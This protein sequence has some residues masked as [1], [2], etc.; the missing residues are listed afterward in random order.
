LQ[1]LTD[2]ARTKLIDHLA[3]RRKPRVDATSVHA[4]LALQ[5]GVA[6]ARSLHLC[7]PLSG[8][9]SALG[10]KEMLVVAILTFFCVV[11]VLAVTI[12]LVGEI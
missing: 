1:P 4:R 11:V 3:R 12:G 2:G 10:Q 9:S 6:T 8:P 5:R 7:A